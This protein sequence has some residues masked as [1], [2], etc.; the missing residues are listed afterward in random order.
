MV[1]LVLWRRQQ[2]WSLVATQQSWI[3]LMMLM[4][5]RHDLHSHWHSHL[6]RP[7]EF[8]VPGPPAAAGQPTNGLEFQAATAATSR[9]CRSWSL[10]LRWQLHCCVSLHS[11]CW[12]CC[13]CWAGGPVHPEPTL[14]AASPLP[15]APAAS[16]CQLQPAPGQE[17]LLRSAH[18][19]P[20]V[21]AA[22]ALSERAAEKRQRHSQRQRLKQRG[23]P[24]HRA[25]KTTQ[26]RRAS[27]ALL[28]LPLQCRVRPA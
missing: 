23:G 16:P 24:S 11:H 7:S 18:D 28:L 1:Q 4:P 22:A 12:P 20:A 8:A 6:Q 2:S 9:A 5:G 27:C 19:A 13:R 26:K 25:R 17:P 15:A 14:E 10:K 21:A 3:L